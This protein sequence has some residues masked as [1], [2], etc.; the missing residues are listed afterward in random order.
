MAPV[1]ARRPILVLGGG[2]AGL[3]CA[4]YLSRLSARV[5][6]GRDILLIEGRDSTGGWL[7]SA[8]YADGVVHELGPRSI[9]TA[10]A[11]GLNTL[12]LVRPLDVLRTRS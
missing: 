3:T 2:V 10:G 6:R 1:D 12:S 4:Y 9:R 5:L 7:Q 11:V 8:R